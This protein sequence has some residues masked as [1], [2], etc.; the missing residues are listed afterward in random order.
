MQDSKDDEMNKMKQDM[1]KDTI[2]MTVQRSSGFI[3][4]TLRSLLLL[5]MMTVGVNSVWGQTDYSGTYYIAFFCDEANVVATYNAQNPT[6]N[7]Y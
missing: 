5:V 6:N 4:T 1:R 2:L 7:Y 3:S